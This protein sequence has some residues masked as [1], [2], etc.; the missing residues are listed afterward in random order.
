MNAWSRVKQWAYQAS[1]LSIWLQTSISDGL[2][3][4]FVSAGRPQE[5]SA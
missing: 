5:S 2:G 1:D 3:M 4:T